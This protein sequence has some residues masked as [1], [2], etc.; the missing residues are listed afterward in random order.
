MI[1]DHQNHDHHD[2]STI[3]IWCPDRPL[4]SLGDFLRSPPIALHNVATIQHTKCEQS[5]RGRARKTQ[6]SASA[7]E[8]G[9][10]IKSQTGDTSRARHSVPFNAVHC[11]TKSHAQPDTA[12]HTYRKTAVSQL[13]LSAVQMYNFKLFLCLCLAEN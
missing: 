4:L 11:H 1:T 6:E 13:P 3:S 12:C 2:V 8:G 7:V 9:S 10:R 5:G